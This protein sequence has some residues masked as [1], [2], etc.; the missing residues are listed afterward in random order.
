MD[1]EPRLYQD[2][3]VAQTSSSLRP[4]RNFFSACAQANEN[5]CSPSGLLVS[6]GWHGFRTRTPRGVALPAARGPSTGTLRRT[7]WPR[8]N[9]TYGERFLGQ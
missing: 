4:V 7:L 5:R 6:A 2:F 1:C 9:S 8:F 3:A